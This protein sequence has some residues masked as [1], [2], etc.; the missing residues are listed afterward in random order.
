MLLWEELDSE[1]SSHC[2]KEV[3]KGGTLI[4]WP[5]KSKIAAWTILTE[6]CAKRKCYLSGCFSDWP[7][8]KPLCRSRVSRSW[9]EQHNSRDFSLADAMGPLRMEIPVRAQTSEETLCHVTQLCKSSTWRTHLFYSWRPTC[10]NKW[11]KI[12]L[13]FF[14]KYFNL[15]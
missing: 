8:V 13:F 12:D 7:D 1:G 2:R 4:L 6:F 3:E 5:T 11:I 9:W 14:F 15:P 10:H